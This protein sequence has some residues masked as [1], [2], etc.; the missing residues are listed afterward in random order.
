VTSW[1]PLASKGLFF[2]EVRHLG[3]KLVGHSVGHLVSY[4]F[5]DKNFGILYLIVSNRIKASKQKDLNTQND[6]L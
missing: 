6:H 4:G 3:A 5:R 1:G 2:H